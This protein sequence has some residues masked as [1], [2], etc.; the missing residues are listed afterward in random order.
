[1]TAT[2]VSIMVK[3]GDHSDW[4]DFDLPIPSSFDGANS[5]YIIKYHIDGYFG[6]SKSKQYL[7]DIAERI[8]NTL[9]GTYRIQQEDTDSQYLYKLSRFEHLERAPSYTRDLETNAYNGS[10]NE[11]FQALRQKAYQMKRNGTLDLESLVIYGNYISNRSEH[12]KYLAKNVYSWTEEKYQPRP[13]PRMTRIEACKIATAERVK[14][15]KEAVTNALKWK[16]TFFDSITDTSLAKAFNVS[17]NSFYKYQ[18]AAELLSQAAE[19]LRAG[20]TPYGTEMNSYLERVQNSAKRLFRSTKTAISTDRNEVVI[21]F[22]TGQD[23][24]GGL[25]WT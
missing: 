15:T 12:I 14:R 1:M 10:R 17:R 24:K 25:I 22:D 21:I 8:A 7:H 2:A 16:D 9:G 6:T 13:Q 20:V 23:A 18:A 11:I 5:S 3:N 19:A 4:M